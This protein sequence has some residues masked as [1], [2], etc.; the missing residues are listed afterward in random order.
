MT[1]SYFVQNSVARP[2]RGPYDKS[3]ILKLKSRVH[4]KNF[5]ENDRNLLEMT[6]YDWQLF[7]AK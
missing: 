5:I 3:R 6:Q 1:G 7:C 2:T 4:I